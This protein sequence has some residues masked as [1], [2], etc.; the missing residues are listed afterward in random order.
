LADFQAVTNEYNAEQ[1]MVIAGSV[2][3]GDKTEALADKLG[4][5]FPIA[6]GMNA[7][8]VS[9]LTGGFYDK[10]KKYLQPTNIIVRPDKT[11]EIASYSTGAMGRFVARD[12][13]GVIKYYKSQKK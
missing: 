12:V 2:D 6:C 10:E 9:R 5:T 7:E 1:I 13:L 8:K 4:L 11:V 3:P